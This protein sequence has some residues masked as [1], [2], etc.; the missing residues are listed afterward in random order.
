LRV[1]LLDK[2]ELP[3]PAPLLDLLLA[4]DC[5][6]HRYVK[7]NMHEP[8]HRVSR[9]EAFNLAHPVFPHPTR[10]IVGDADVEGPVAIARQNVDAR[11]HSLCR[12]PLDAR[13][14]GHDD[15]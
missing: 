5:V 6:G 1:R 4:L 13:F 12:F 7:F 10:N 3:S 15:G 11:T 2:L 9:G 8:I 14:R